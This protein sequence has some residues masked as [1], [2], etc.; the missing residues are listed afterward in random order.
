MAD[1]R[2]AA[3]TTWLVAGANT[4]AQPVSNPADDIPPLAP[5]LQEIPPSFWEQHGTAVTLGALAL[6]ALAGCA[7][8]WLCRPKPPA[9][10]P[11]EGRARAELAALGGQLEDGLVVSRVS[12][13]LRRYL[14]AAFNLPPG[15]STTTEFCATLGRSET[16]GPELATAV[17]D[18]LRACDERK[19]APA[20]GGE[21]CHAASRALALVEQA[22]ARRARLRAA[23]GPAQSA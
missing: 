21:P 16:I 12:R 19:F 17:G 1:W 15:E 7:V 22:E 3:A 8:W 5:P 2:W 20:A 18:F 4:F 13:V 9:L 11:P 10:V 23:A 14:G 6:L